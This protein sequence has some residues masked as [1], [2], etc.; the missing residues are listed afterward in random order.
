MKQL[1][2]Q[3]RELLSVYTD[4]EI[5]VSQTHTTPDEGEILDRLKEV[6]RKLCSTT[7]MAQSAVVAVLRE[8]RAK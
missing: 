1:I 2:D 8:R 4:A 6:K 3:A 7:P 5:L